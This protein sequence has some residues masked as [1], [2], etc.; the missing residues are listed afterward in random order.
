MEDDFLREAR[1]EPRPEFARALR[2]KLRNLEMDEA[3][4]AAAAPRA[5]A[6]DAPNVAGPADRSADWIPTPVRRF[7]WRMAWAG[8]GGVAVAA[9]ALLFVFPSVRASAQAFLDLFRV[10]N[11]AAVSIDA[12]RME[13][14]E[15]ISVDLKALL[16]D[17]L[18]MDEKPGPSAV[19]ATPEEAGRAAGFTVRLP[20]VLPAGLTLDSLRV[21]DGAVASLTVDASRLNSIMRS[22]DISDLQVP[23]GLDGRVVTVRTTPMV[24]ARYHGDR[25]EAYLVQARS[26][27]VNL[28]AGVDLAQLGE[29]GLRIA[30]L[31][32]GEAH[33]FARSID[34]RSTLILPVPASASSFNQV[35]VSGNPGLL[36]TTKE[37]AAERSP[38]PDSQPGGAPG[39]STGHHR[40]HRSGSILLWSEGEM[41]YA[42][43]GSLHQ[44]DA[45]EMAE[46][47]R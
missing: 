6:A 9:V 14:L 24:T 26:P 23:P 1:R 16:G 17:R 28:P 34:W 20:A 38:D 3:P 37:D 35:T 29:I 4:G 36:I 47:L 10:R 39:D 46:S 5:A 12:A 32:P 27:E 25:R 31:D 30:G 8:L 44:A 19:V 2:E 21:E 22:L 40:R 45:L 11:F 41:V 13:Q 7:R 43:A 18:E 33:R 15:G 42:V